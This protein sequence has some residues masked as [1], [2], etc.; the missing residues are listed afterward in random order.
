[1][2]LIFQ[3]SASY[4]FL[5][6]IALSVEHI[7]LPQKLNP[8]T[9]YSWFLFICKTV[10]IK[11]KISDVQVWK[12]LPAFFW[13]WGLII[14]VQLTI[15]NYETK[16]FSCGNHSTFSPFWFFSQPCLYSKVLHD[17]QIGSGKNICTQLP[18]CGC[19]SAYLQSNVSFSMPMICLSVHC[20]N[21]EGK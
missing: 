7:F 6:K 9:H 5:F 2:S 1:M 10:T 11:G 16:L 3:V 8:I 18:M 15:A 13:L 21:D 20:N 4:L 17:S 19:T 14:A 12:H